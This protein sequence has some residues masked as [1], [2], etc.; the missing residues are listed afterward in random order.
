MVATVWVGVLIP[1]AL[2]ISDLLNPGMPKGP[3]WFAIALG[4]VIA[5][6]ILLLTYPMYYEITPTT[7]LVRSGVFRMKVPLNSIQEVFPERYARSAPAWSL[8]R[9]R[10]N[11]RNRW[12]TTWVHISPKDKGKFMQDLADHVEGLQVTDG[13]VIRRQ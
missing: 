3:G 5:G 7:L 6:L 4:I 2:G 10:I 1:F 12:G 11:Y 9:L 13:R 8:D